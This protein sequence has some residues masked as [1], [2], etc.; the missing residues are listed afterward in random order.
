MTYEQTIHENNIQLMMIIGI[1]ILLGIGL[2]LF[3]DY[4]TY[5]KIKREVDEKQNNSSN[6]T[7]DGE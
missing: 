5:R 6:S 2:S 3:I 4:L 1:V 7:E